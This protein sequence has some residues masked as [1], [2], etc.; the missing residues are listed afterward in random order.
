MPERK[1]QV[2]VGVLFLLSVAILV[3]GVM[4]FKEIRL[5]ERS[6]EILGQFRT[7]TG[8]LKGDPVE[9]LGVPSGEVAEIRFEDGS[10]LVRIRLNREIQLYPGTRIAIENVGIMGQ[11]LVAI[12]PGPEQGEPLPPGS[13]LQGF[14]NPGIPELMLDMGDALGSFRVLTD[15]IDSL[16]VGFGEDRQ[17]QVER[18]F[19][20]LEKV[21][22]DLAGLVSENRESLSSSLENLDAVLADLHAALGGRGENLGKTL[23]HAGSAVA[24]LD[25]SMVKL[26]TVTGRLDSLL[27]RLESGEGTAG[28]LIQDD[29]IYDELQITLEEARLLL[30]DV[31]VNPGRYFKFSVF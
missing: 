1:H 4:W 21:S 17:A 22:G 23:D 16:L 15:H 31:R 30:E 25:S 11:K 28:K 12:Y 29:R 7:S 5:G 13:R 2:Q 9:V 26:G 19:D 8:L 18:T 14:Y 3:W 6:Y 20:N 10:A 27:A 24:Q